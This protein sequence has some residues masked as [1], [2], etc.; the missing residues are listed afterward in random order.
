MTNIERMSEA[1]ST[2]LKA[3]MP[4]N[5][6]ELMS[7]LGTLVDIWASENDLEVS[8]ALSIFEELADVQKQVYAYEGMMVKERAQA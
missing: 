3:A 2:M 6:V 5:K 1:L 8:E 7:A 4:L